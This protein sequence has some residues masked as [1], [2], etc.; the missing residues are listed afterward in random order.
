[1][2][3]NI[4][5]ELARQIR[6]EAALKGVT[7]PSLVANKLCELYSYSGPGSELVRADLGGRKVRAS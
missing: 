7:V 1:M 4:P 3:V 5:E 6:A 2:T